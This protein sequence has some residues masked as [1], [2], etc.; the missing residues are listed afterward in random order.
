MIEIYYL[1]RKFI[2]ET[3][4]INPVSRNFSLENGKDNLRNYFSSV[5]CILYPD[6][7]DIT[8]GQPLV[9]YI[10]S[11]WDMLINQE[12][13]KTCAVEIERIIKQDGVFHVQKSTGLFVAKNA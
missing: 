4:E 3:K 10:N 7:L 11:F 2:P 9:D 5:D 12:Q 1:I 13:L 8:E 6:S